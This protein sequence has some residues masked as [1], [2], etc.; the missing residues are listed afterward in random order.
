MHHIFNDRF[1]PLRIIGTT[2]VLAVLTLGQG[3]GMEQAVE[4]VERAAI[5]TRDAAIE[6]KGAAER[7][8]QAAGAIDLY[9]YKTKADGSLALKDGEKQPSNAK[10]V[11]NLFN[12]VNACRRPPLDRFINALGIRHIG[13]TNARLFARHYGSFAAFQDAAQKAAQPGEAYDDMLSI[14]GVGA[15]VAGGVIEFFK[16]THNREA[17]TRLLKEVAPQEMRIAASSSPVAG[18]TVVFTGTLETM[19]RDEAKAQALAL[20]A[21]VSGSVSAKT[22]YVVAGPGAGSKLKNAEA[23]GVR[24]MS[25]EEWR[26]FI[27]A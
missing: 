1:G 24:V 9:T 10:S 14:E 6:A 12:A 19:T 17:V 21:K 7:A 8:V 16:E 27:G 23:L 2:A 22:D 20:G 4:S 11:D 15:L 18:K 3:C 5:Q 13:E 25:E 26:A